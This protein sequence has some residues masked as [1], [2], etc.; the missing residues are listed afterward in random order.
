MKNPI[1]SIINLYNKLSNIGKI[2]IFVSL[3]LISIVFFKYV[4]KVN[5]N[6]LKNK[7]GFQQQQD[8]LF[9][10][11]T[12]IYDDFYANIYDYLVFNDTKNDYEVGV[13]MNQNVPNSKSVVLDIGCGTGHHVAKMSENK[14][15][16]VI[17]ID[18]SPS[19]IRKA[20]E[21][22]P[23]LNFKQADALNK[24]TFNNNTFTHILCMYF[25]IYYIQNKIEFFNNCMDWLMP[26]GYL[27]LHLVDRNKFDPILPPGNPL[28]IVSPQ[29]YAKERIT[30]TKVKFNEFVYNANFKLNESSNTAV[31]DEK[32]K[33]NDGK[34][35]KQEHILYMDDVSTIVNMAQNAGFLLHGKV[36][37]LKVAYEYQFLYI[38][39]KPG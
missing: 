26:G 12:E 4:D 32:F 37:L 38:F 29:K 21:N 34:V 1:K 7:E 5:P 33:F 23:N 2:L 25:T 14:N 16:E 6:N 28:F 3:L 9:K 20:K 24:D 11:G 17:G 36:D 30:S 31:F 13:I 39:V 10:K 27:V 35:R 22:Y 19:M 8:F 18:L 15:L